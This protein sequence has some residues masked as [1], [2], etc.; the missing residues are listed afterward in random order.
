MLDVDREQLFLSAVMKNLRTV[1]A[2]WTWTWI[3][4]DY[5]EDNFCLVRT[6]VGDAPLDLQLPKWKT[7]L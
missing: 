1:D 3:H 6:L 5:L 2:V 4:V 7:L